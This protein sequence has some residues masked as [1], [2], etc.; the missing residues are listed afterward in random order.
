M[1]KHSPRI[2]SSSPNP[3]C[4]PSW[5]DQLWAAKLLGVLNSAVVR[6]EINT[7]CCSSQQG[8]FYWGDTG[9]Q[10]ENKQFHS[11]WKL[12]PHKTWERVCAEQHNTALR[13]ATCP[14]Q[15]RPLPVSPCAP[16]QDSTS[17]GGFKTFKIVPWAQP[18]YTGPTSPAFMETNTSW[19]GARITERT[20]KLQGF[21]S[22]K[23]KPKLLYGSISTKLQQ[24]G[25]WHTVHFLA[26]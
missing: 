25:L 3:S 14:Q 12:Q 26:I 22:A 15:L 21:T 24:T 20:G 11:C 5:M 4:A 7:A 23:I 1:L 6:A 9:K 8:K 16:R 10:G 2:K 19:F 18:I 13:C 17:W